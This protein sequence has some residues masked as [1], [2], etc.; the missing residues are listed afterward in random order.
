MYIEVSAESQRGGVR[1][2]WWGV[3]RNIG[4]WS[5]L[6]PEGM[7]WPD[8]LL[9]AKLFF[10]Y[11]PQGK[12]GFLFWLSSRIGLTIFLSFYPWRDCILL[13]RIFK[14]CLPFFFFFLLTLMWMQG[15]HRRK[16]SFPF[17]FYT[18]LLFPQCPFSCC[19]LDL[20]HKANIYA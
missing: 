13:L 14:I 3:L 15:R 2:W 17:Y 19:R 5:I 9:V 20:R 4:Y 18:Y 7:A 1:A 12:D 10:I 6:I 8:W 11:V 16:G